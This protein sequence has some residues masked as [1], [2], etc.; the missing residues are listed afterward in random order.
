M[1][2][3]FDAVAIELQ[4]LI[5]TSRTH[6]THARH[7][8]THLVVDDT[9]PIIVRRHSQ[10]GCLSLATLQSEL[11]PVLLKRVVVVWHYS[12]VAGPFTQTPN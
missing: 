4:L 12:I 10:V 5:V 6:V 9:W 11:V 8:R 1:P 3:H 7:S 2:F